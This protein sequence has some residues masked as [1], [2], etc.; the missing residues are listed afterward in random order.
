MQ[1]KNIFR[2]FWFWAI[3]LIIFIRVLT[4]VLVINDV[5]YTGAQEKGIDWWTRH[6][7]DE[8][9][10]Y[11]SAQ[12]L[13]KGEVIKN[14]PPIGYSMFL[15]PFL[16][17]FGAD[18][19]S[20]IAKPVI[21]FQGII[22]YAIA[23]VLVYLIAEAV[24]KNRKKTLLIAALF[25]VYPYLFYFFADFLFHNAELLT[26]FAVSRFKQL[27]YLVILSDPLSS[28]IVLFSLYFVLNIVNN[29]D[30]KGW[31]S[32]AL[33]LFSGFSVLLRMQNII[34]VP[35]YLILLGL[36]RK[37]KSIY[38]FIIGGLPF[39]LLFMFFN[40][41]SHDS[42]LKT[43]YGFKKG[44]NNDIPMIS[45]K[46][47][48][49]II[50][51]PLEYSPWLIVPIVLGMLLLLVGSWWLIKNN[52]KSGLVITSYFFIVILFLSFI[53]PVFRNP[54]YFL[55]IFPILFILTYSGLEFLFIKTYEY[56]RKKI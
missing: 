27:M 21:F 24:F 54:R 38:G 15:T 7:G 25:I 53:E 17:T 36:F 14:S 2:S 5:P 47:S 55:A 33:G 32:M 44:I 46:Y 11:A 26:K 43:T 22:L 16:L 51:Y 39:L 29:K 3:L 20:Q 37:I 23:V 40:Y 30:K 56:F 42:I 41:V 1:L 13:S 45:Y 52:K 12:A 18:E 6:G 19:I 49:R 9:R 34:L 8:E 50:T 48:L 31:K 4:L 10:Y 28:V 35:L